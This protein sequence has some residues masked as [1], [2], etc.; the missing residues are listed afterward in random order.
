MKGA[1]FKASTKEREAE[2]AALEALPDDSIDTSDIP[3]IVNWPDAERG[4]FY[5]PVKKQI[6]L[7]LD[8]DVVAWFKRQVPGDAAIRPRSIAPCDSTCSEA[9][10]RN[11]GVSSRAEAASGPSDTTL[12]S[13]WSTATRSRPRAGRIPRL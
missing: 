4:L 2:L 8:A 11:P 3:E 5:R 7:R 6:T 1:T 9:R 12:D 13:A 10:V